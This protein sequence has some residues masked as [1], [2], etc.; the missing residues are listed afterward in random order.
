M[1]EKQNIFPPAKIAIFV[2][3]VIALL[4]VVA[5]VM[6]ETGVKVGGKSFYF[7]SLDDIFNADKDKIDVEALIQA[8]KDSLEAYQT[9]LK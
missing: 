1:N 7:V 8:R 2:A 5:A 6:P 9:R 4:G 3:V